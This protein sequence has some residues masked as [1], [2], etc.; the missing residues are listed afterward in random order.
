[1][2]IKLLVYVVG[3]RIGMNHTEVSY[4]DLNLIEVAQDLVLA[5][6]LRFLS[7]LSCRSACYFTGVL[8]SP[9]TTQRL[10]HAR[11]C[12]HRKIGKS[13]Y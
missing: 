1:M 4:W 13:D 2:G 6:L 3:K 11:F 8:T 7:F 10:L 5:L 12:H 9:P